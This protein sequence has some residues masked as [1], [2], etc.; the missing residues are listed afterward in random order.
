MYN[1]E[2]SERNIAGYK[3]LLQVTLFDMG[4][5]RK[6]KGLCFAPPWG[7]FYKPEGARRHL[8]IIRFLSTLTIVIVKLESLMK[9]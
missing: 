8:K 3:T 2:V 9:I 4:F 6:K 5:E 7:N 1:R